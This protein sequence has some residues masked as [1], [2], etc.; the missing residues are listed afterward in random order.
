[1]AENSSDHIKEF[2]AEIPRSGED[3]LGS[4][5]DWK[6]IHI[7]VDDETIWLKGFTDEQA[8]SSEI[9]Q[10]PDFLLYEFREGL[11]FKKDALVPSK[12]MR[13]GLLWTPI[14]KALHLSFPG[15]N[16]NYFGIHEKITITL[17]EIS[18]EQPAVAL[19]TKI[20]DVKE[21]IA[22]VP[23]FKLE[24]INWL[25]IGDYALFVGTP[26]LSFPGKAFWTKDGHLLPAGFDFE[27]KNMS[28]FL[29]QKYNRDSDG[30]LLWDENGNYLSIR[31]SDFQPLFVSSFRLT[32]KSKEWK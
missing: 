10:L 27:F 3:F 30:W 26:V 5:R 28:I 18:E 21:I 4:V 32:I 13:T 6:N 24:R 31:N 7:A 20:S 9:H 22:G 14:D 19:L 1:M 12:K 23:K 15:S 2:W 16:Q 8:V 11:L 17:K 29:Q 25:L